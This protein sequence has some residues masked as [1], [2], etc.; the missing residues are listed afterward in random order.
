MSIVS[1]FA[2]LAELAAKKAPRDEALAL[3]QRNAARTVPEGGLGLPPG[4]TAMER[5][6]AMNYRE[7][8]HGTSAADDFSQFSTPDV[9][10]TPSAVESGGYA[11]GHHLGGEGVAPRVMPLMGRNIDDSL[12]IDSLIENAINEGDDVGDAVEQGIGQSLG[13][14]K[15]YATFSH[16]DVIGSDEHDAIISLYPRSGDLRSRFAAFDPFRR[17][18]SDLLAG[19]APYAL[20]AAGAAGLAAM[21]APGESEAGIAGHLAKTADL[22]ALKIAQKADAAGLPMAKVYDATGW[23]KGADG[24]WRWEFDDSGAKFNITPAT[25]QENPLTHGYGDLNLGPVTDIMLHP[26]LAKAYSGAEIA[27]KTFVKDSMTMLNSMSGAFKPADKSITLYA[28]ASAEQGKST[29]LHETQHA[30]QQQE[31]FA[32]GGLPE[33]FVENDRTIQQEL[34]AL[35]SN[36]EYRAAARAGDRQHP[37]MSREQELGRMLTQAWDDPTG[38]NRYRSLAGEVEARNVQTRMG[39]TQDERRMRPFWKTEDVPRAQQ[40]VHGQSDTSAYAH[41]MDLKR[42]ADARA[43]TH[44]PRAS[45]TPGAEAARAMAIEAMNPASWPL[46]WG[47][48][49]LGDPQSRNY[50]DPYYSYSGSRR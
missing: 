47:S 32:Q 50:S 9:Y 14:N 13:Q 18:E 45:M 20:P 31:G 30:I 33:Y 37:A 40:I 49:E 10:T 6:R 41:M 16:P 17:G 23:A 26:E 11:M 29:L 22:A 42:A 12:R 5:A 43:R 27:P 4:N 36:P 28:P 2:T 19:L 25:G 38:Y 35:R 21:A 7:I 48:R 1:R 3:A 8:Y 39:M 24:K 44:G 46:L 34:N 15:R